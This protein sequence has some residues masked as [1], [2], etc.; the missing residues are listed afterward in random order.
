VVDYWAIYGLLD[1]MDSVN[2]D[3]DRVMHAGRCVMFRYAFAVLEKA[4]IR[5]WLFRSPADTSSA[6][7]YA[8]RT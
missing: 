3:S 4:G 1:T 5:E 2:A 8:P 6:V 7:Q